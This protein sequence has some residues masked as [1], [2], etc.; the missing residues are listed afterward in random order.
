MTTLEATRPEAPPVTRPR[1]PR[2]RIL[3]GFRLFAALLVVSWHYTAFG[4]GSDL[5]PY[6]SVPFL[7]P[8]S[9]YGWLGVELFFLISGFVICMSSIGHTL[10]EFVTSRITRLYP[11]YWIGIVLTTTV[12]VLWPI[13]RSS[14]PMSNV[15]LNLTMMQSGFGVRSVDSVYWTL[16]VELHFYVLFALVVWR[17]VTYN[18]VVAFCFS[19]LAIAYAT[20]RMSIKW[21]LHFVGDYAPFFIAGIA[22]FLMHHFGQKPLL[23]LL[24]VLSFPVGL[25]VI[26][27][28]MA[29]SNLRLHQHVPTWPA[30]ALV[31]LF[32]LLIATVA[33]GWLKLDW[34]WLGVAGALTYPLYLV[35]E[36]IGWAIMKPLQGRV[37]GPLLFAGV[38]AL[39]LGVA[40]LIHRYVEKPLAPH[41]KNLVRAV[42]DAPKM[43]FNKITGR[44][45]TDTGTRSITSDSPGPVSS[46][47]TGAP[48]AAS[49]PR[50]RS[51]TLDVMAL[52][53]RAPRIDGS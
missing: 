3:D 30:I 22:F 1:R 49:T 2:I 42:L 4:H 51:A 17:G 38:V 26:K 6:A 7:Y 25:P 45:Q 40:W 32:Y 39:M 44:D 27:R 18:K 21:D 35:H 33:L 19:W 10:G 14:I 12:L 37:P 29:S 20:Q 34:K 13:E 31:A 41:L 15:L 16:W 53:E 5:K 8:V 23:W 48:V 9:A 47:V 28:T 43:V 52:E 11:A 46:S 50:M 24:V 36:F